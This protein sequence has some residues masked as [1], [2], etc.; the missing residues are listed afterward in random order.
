MKFETIKDNKTLF[1]TFDKT[2]MPPLPQ[3]N[4]MF[5][6]GYKFKID[7]KNATKKFIEQILKEG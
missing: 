2:C 3:I 1:Y 7:G 4:L 6:A 5:K